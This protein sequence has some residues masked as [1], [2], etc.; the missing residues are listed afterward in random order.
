MKEATLNQL[1]A[2]RA[3]RQVE[4]GGGGGGSKN[5]SSTR[6]QST[7]ISPNA[8]FSRTRVLTGTQTPSRTCAHNLCATDNVPMLCVPAG[9]GR[10]AVLGKI[11]RTVTN[12]SN[13][14]GSLK[15]LFFCTSHIKPGKLPQEGAYT[16]K[17]ADILPFKRDPVILGSTG[18]RSEAGLQYYATKCSGQE[19][20]P[21]SRVVRG[22][23]A[24]TH[25]READCWDMLAEAQATL[26]AERKARAAERGHERRQGKEKGDAPPRM[27]SFKWLTA[28]G[29]A[30]AKRWAYSTVEELEDGLHF[31]IEAGAEEMYDGLCK[32]QTGN[33]RAMDFT[34]AY[35]LGCIRLKRFRN[36]G[37]LADLIG[38]KDRSLSKYFHAAVKIVSFI[39]RK[40]VLRPHDQEYID[41]NRTPMMSDPGEFGPA[42][43]FPA[44]LQLDGFKI[45][46]SYRI[47]GQPRPH[48]N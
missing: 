6:S 29:D 37:A 40:T 13:R 3:R 44:E 39:A 8:G 43:K 28:E 23:T 27:L 33:P 31:L 35:A 26:A 2:A 14:D 20:G 48:R 24:A 15:T 47:A 32:N 30:R 4:G 34:D 41:A 46:A 11:G 12:S 45:R 25:T 17:A 42:G 1:A 9:R 16:L 5:G 21:N 22:A 36:F 7:M 38:V 10:E 19:K 18:S